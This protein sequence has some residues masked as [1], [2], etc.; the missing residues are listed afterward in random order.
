MRMLLATATTILLLLA[1]SSA[2]W[3]GGHR[4]HHGGF[5]RNARAPQDYGAD[6]NR[7]GRVTTYERIRYAQKL[8]YEKR[9]GS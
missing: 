3:A 9:H 7:D 8:R 1:F 5:G 2:A 4:R 6:L